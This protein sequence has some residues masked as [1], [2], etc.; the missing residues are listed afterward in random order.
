MRQA[1]ARSAALVAWTGSARAA[2]SGLVQVFTQRGGGG[3][4]QPFELVGRRGPG[5]GRT[6]PYRPQRTDA[7]HD[8]VA[9][10]GRRGGHP[11]KDR[12][13]GGLG[14]D[15]IRLAALPAGAPVW[16]VDLHDGDVL[17]QQV[18]GQAGAVAASAFDPDAVQASVPAKPAQQL[19][20]AAPGGWE[21]PVA[22]QPSLLVDDGG[23]VGTAVGVNPADDDPG[24]LGH[25]GTAFPLGHEPGQAR[26][27]RAGG[28][29]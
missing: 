15:R 9:S 23:V 12:A 6:A 20:V 22:K 14:V 10:L 27:G 21:L 7:L 24:A 19:P 28:H 26:T 1:T 11:G 8:P 2:S 17:V 4:Q 5:L 29:Q 18:A 16:S 13:G 3:H 25:A